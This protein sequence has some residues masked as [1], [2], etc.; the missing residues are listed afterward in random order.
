MSGSARFLFHVTQPRM[1]GLRS[2]SEQAQLPLAETLRRMID[3]CSQERVANE[4]F[5]HLSGTLRTGR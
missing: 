5:P 2:L 4:L 3:F 1:S